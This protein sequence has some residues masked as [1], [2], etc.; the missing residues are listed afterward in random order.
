MTRSHVLFVVAVALPVTV[1]G[2]QEVTPAA[3]TSPSPAST[4]SPAGPRPSGVPAPPADTGPAATALEAAGKRTVDSGSYLL[5]LT[6]D[7]GGADGAPAVHGEGAVESPTRSH[8]NLVVTLS[9]GDVTSESVAYDGH[10]WTRSNGD[11]WNP[12]DPSTATNQGDVAA[13]LVG[14]SSVRDGGPADRNG[15][16]CEV[17]AATFASGAQRLAIPGVRAA[18]TAINV[19]VGRADGRI[20][21]EEMTF[22]DERGAVTGHLVID[23]HGF[24]ARVNVQPPA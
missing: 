1:A 17:Y 18:S 2:C 3:S 16:A 10:Y 21:A 11:P 8:F 4:P 24:G 15:V 6:A 19:W 14:A 5:T 13:N 22:Q 12:A 23:I 7:G 20:L 9:S